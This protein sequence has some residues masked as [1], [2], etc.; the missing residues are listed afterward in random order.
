MDT[1]KPIIEFRRVNHA[2]A[3]PGG[4][5][6][7]VLADIDAS[8]REGEILGLLGRSGSGKSTF[9]RIAAGLIQPTSGEVH[10]RG[11]P[12]RGPSEGISVVFQTF[13]LYPWLTVRENVEAGLDAL[14]L[15]RAEVQRRAEAAID[16]IG[17]DGFQSAYPRELS[18][19]MRQRVGFARAIVADPVALLMD[20]PFSALDVLTAE[21]LRNDFLDLW[22]GHRLPLKSVLLVTHNIEEAVLL[23]DRILVL[24]SNPGRICAEIAIPLAHPRDRLSTGFR[25]VVDEI[26]SILTLRS[27]ESLR[28]HGQPQV[29]VGSPLPRASVN[30]VSGLIETLLSAHY[31][32]HAELSE[33]ARTLSLEVDDLFPIAEALHILGFAELKGRSLKLT[34]AGRVFAESVTDERKRLWREHLLRFVPLAAHIHHVLEERESHWAPLLRFQAELE[35]HLTHREADR[36]LRAVI[37]WGRYA[38]LFSY[39]AKSHR[40]LSGAQ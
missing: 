24:S 7:V 17:L 5:P 27:L 34:P 19:G 26:Y 8:M 18:G 22:I 13:A 4:E 2:F 28:G 10:Y 15:P 23:C 25:A 38:E 11:A 16:L 36:T 31:G 33:F 35:D 6:L 32:G 37:G 1:Q 30:Q 29:G 14:R 20:E 3:K 9:L 21:T 39:D 12:L 40:F